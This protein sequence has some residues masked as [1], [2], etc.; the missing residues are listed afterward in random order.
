MKTTD[1]LKEDI[2]TDAHEMHLD[3]EVQMA[4]KDCYTAADDAIALHKL[5]RHVSES[6]GIEGW[7]AAKI[8]LASDYLK[9]VREHLEYQL[10][11]TAGQSAE[12]DVV[13]PIAEG[14]LDTPGQA[15]SPAAQAIIR[16]ILLQRTDLLAKYGP[17]KVGAAVDEVADFIGDVEEIGSSDVSG[18][19]RHVEQ[20]LGNMGDDVAEGY[21]DLNDEG[22]QP[23]DLSANPSF[24]QLVN[25]YTQLYYQGHEG[26]YDEEESAESDAIEQYVA[27][28]FGQKG[29]DHLLR[30]AQASHFGRDDGRGSGHIR[31]SNLGRPSQPAGDFRTTK[32]GKMHS[33]DAKG[34]KNKV[35]NRLGR[36]PEP[37]L[38]EGVAEGVAETMTMD[39]AMKVLRHYGAG[40]FKTT[41]NELHFYKQGRPFSVDLV[42]NPDA[43]RSVTLSSLNSATRG[44]KGQGVAK[45][46]LAE[47]QVDELDVSKTLKFA[48]K[49][50]KGQQ[51]GEKPY[52]THPRSVAAT[53]KKFFG[54]AFTP[55]AIKVALLH[56]V[57][58]DTP[59]KLNQLAKMGYSPEV[60]E[61][62]QLLT[63]N[64]ALS[65][66]DNIKAIIASDNKLA[67]MV[68]YADNYQNF[69]GDKSSWNPERVAHSQKKYLA[70]LDMLG[71]KLGIK[72]HLSQSKQQGVAEG[73]DGWIGNP[74]KWKE[75]VLQ[76]HGP[77]VVFKNY[78]HPGQPGKRSV[79]AINTQGKQVGVYQRHN[80]MGMVQPSQQGVAEGDVVP[81]KRPQ[82]LSWEQLPKDVLRLANDW[83]W[84]SEDDLGL[85]AVLDPKGYGSGTRNELQY[86]T[87]KLQ[88]RGWAIDFNDEHDGPG[89]YNIRL[90]N[91]RGQSLL[92]PIEDAQDFKGWAQGTQSMSEGLAD[93]F[94]K[95]A[96]D[97]GMN[98][99]LRGTP[100]EER[101][102]TD[103]MLKQR[104]ADRANAPK[105]A[106]VSD[107][108]RAGLEARLKDLE[109]KFDPDFEYSD[110]YSFWTKQN[111]LKKHINSIKQ[112]LKQGVDEEKI[113]GV[114]G[115][116]CWPGKRYAGK[117]KKADGTYKDKCIPVKKG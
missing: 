55:D 22:M 1:F 104:A 14:M 51:Y 24:K 50:H 96:K 73:S 23:I 113:K 106:P 62:V 108:E 90:T 6:Q 95:M 71:D 83:Y 103:A 52:I 12:A 93:E 38:P 89:E 116:A 46:N 45:D 5:L 42:M 85:D 20:M 36:H 16:R 31:S 11:S 58:E 92:L 79:N 32:A 81:F 100:D 69:T 19:V 99:R 76:A 4:R 98:P 66:A 77:D 102:R 15:D 97:M 49:A 117:V 63:K 18:W 82:A 27:K 57:V 48:T 53:G 34:I 33:Q 47:E 3:H 35:A 56:D 78:T 94:M 29:S 28:R 88:Q 74:A 68:K 65:Y 72:Q 40:H 105:P 26:T 70:S 64:K 21:Y 86:I 75:A 87:A 9:S 110:D 41:S 67:M 107:E 109:A 25:R 114:D 111:E 8:T 7:V 112:R 91:K 60:V 80:K 30:A 37:N 84:A 39:D 61:A 17:E 115:K 59:Y 54:S 44:L 13:L 2:A 43:T 101:A 10:M